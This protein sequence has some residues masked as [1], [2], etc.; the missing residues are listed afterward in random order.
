MTF[1]VTIVNADGAV[2]HPAWTQQQID[3]FTRQHLDTAAE[4]ILLYFPNH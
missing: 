4:T 3:K 2:T 1:T